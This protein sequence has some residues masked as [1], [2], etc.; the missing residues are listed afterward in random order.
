MLTHV[1]GHVTQAIQM[2]QSTKRDV[3]GCLI[4]NALITW[5][6]NR[7]AHSYATNALC[8]RDKAAELIK[9]NTDGSGG[10]NGR[11]TLPALAGVRGNAAGRLS[12]S[13]TQ[14]LGRQ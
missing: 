9:A 12:D 3:Y 10:E 14:D 5:I 13:S 1:Y 11:A 8:K 6:Q 4:Q 7:S 2:K